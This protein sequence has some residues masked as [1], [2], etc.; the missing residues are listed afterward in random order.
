MYQVGD[1]VRLSETGK[2]RLR[3][4][5]EAWGMHTAANRDEVG[6][7]EEV[8]PAD[9]DSGPR[10]SVEFPSG[11]LYNWDADAFVPAD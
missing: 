10:L 11:A 5:P 2:Q 1:P 3:A 6:V 7:V 9:A 8:I 4:M